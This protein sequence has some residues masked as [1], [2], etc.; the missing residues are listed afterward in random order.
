MPDGIKKKVVESVGKIAQG[1]V[2]QLATDLIFEG[3][4]GGT[5]LIAGPDSNGE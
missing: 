1:Q 5:R 2:E 4:S 3:V